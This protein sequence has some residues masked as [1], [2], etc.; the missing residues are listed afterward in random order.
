MYATVDDVKKRSA[1][2]EVKALPDVDIDSYLFRAARWIY[3]STK[4]DY[5]E[6]ADPGI[7]ED[8][9][10]ASIHLVD[11]LWYQDNVDVKEAGMANLQSERIGSY[12]YT[13]MEKAAP[14]GKTG[15]TELDM[16]LDGLKPTL[17]GFGF[18]NVSGPGDYQ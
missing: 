5:S 1:F 9:K 4:V 6:T 17:T 14:G 3:Y 11:L 2:A 10:T 8:L 16:I 18:F 12:S 15:I 13:A 7:L